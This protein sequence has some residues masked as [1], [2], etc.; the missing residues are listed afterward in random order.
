MQYWNSLLTRAYSV[1]NVLLLLRE[2][3]EKQKR[4]TFDL[5]DGYTNHEIN[6][7][8]KQSHCYGHILRYLSHQLPSLLIYKETFVG[9]EPLNQLTQKNINHFYFVAVL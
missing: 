9:Q 6:P 7:I 2:N 1:Q 3:E 5:C 4:L 8:H